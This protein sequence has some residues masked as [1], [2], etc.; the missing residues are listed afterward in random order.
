MMQPTSRLI[1]KVLFLMMILAV[2][3]HFKALDGQVIYG[4]CHPLDIRE[5]TS[6]LE[7]VLNDISNFLLVQPDVLLFL[8]LLGPL[9][10]IRW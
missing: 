8:I 10:Q 1:A 9:G 3:M 2:Q 7:K 4:I 6:L 5:C